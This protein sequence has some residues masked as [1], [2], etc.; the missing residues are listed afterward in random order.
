[1]WKQRF[2]RA[3][4]LNVCSVHGRGRELDKAMEIFNM[5]QHKGVA[6]DE[7][8]YTNMICH[9]GKAGTASLSLSLVHMFLTFYA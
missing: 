3:G 6:L 9:Y 4:V 5:A 8:T 2:N 1:M 7:K